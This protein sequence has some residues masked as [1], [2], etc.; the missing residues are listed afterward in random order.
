MVSK[1]RPRMLA[2]V[3]AVASRDVMVSSGQSVMIV[4]RDK[5]VY[6]CGIVAIVLQR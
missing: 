6:S 5:A 2:M 3:V 1:D 4:A